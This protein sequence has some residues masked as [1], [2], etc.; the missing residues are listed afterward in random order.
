MIV[1]K[2]AERFAQ[3]R[4]IEEFNAVRDQIGQELRA[5]VKGSTI[6]ELP[7]YNPQGRNLTMKVRIPNWITEMGRIDGM[8]LSVRTLGPDP[9]IESRKRA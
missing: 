2:Y 3:V 4:N 9:V 6:V 8:G 1:M 5:T 7:V